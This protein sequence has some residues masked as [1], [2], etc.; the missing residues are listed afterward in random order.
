MLI[1]TH[2]GQV[3]VGNKWS[4]ELCDLPLPARLSLCY[5][6]NRFG[7]MHMSRYI[8][9]CSHYGAWRKARADYKKECLRFTMDFRTQFVAYM[10]APTPNYVMPMKAVEQPDGK[11]KFDEKAYPD[12]LVEGE[13]GFFT[14]GFKLTLDDNS[15]PNGRGS[16]LLLMKFSL[17]DE[18]C[19]A[20]LGFDGHQ[21]RFDRTQPNTIDQVFEYILSSL[22]AF[23]NAKPWD[24]DTKTKIGFG[25]PQ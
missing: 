18:I 13:D 14:T 24:A 8:D 7:G 3:G 25:I 22:G 12:I 17:R 20:R 19:E 2:G 1:L 5:K 11:Y 15:D 9:L 23:F 21:I 4:W 10:D 6:S 16:A